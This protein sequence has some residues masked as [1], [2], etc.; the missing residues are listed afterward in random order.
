M[1]VTFVLAAAIILGCLSRG[2]VEATCYSSCR[3]TFC[4]SVYNNAFNIDQPDKSF[5]TAICDASRSTVIGHVDSTGEAYV[6]DHREFVR[7]SEYKPDGLQQSFSPS[8]FKSY[9]IHDYGK[10]LS[11]IGHETPQANQMEF[12]NNLCVLVPLTAYQ[13]LDRPYGNVVENRHPSTPF[14]DCVSFT[15]YV[16]SGHRTQPPP[17]KYPATEK[18]AYDKSYTKPYQATEKR[19]STGKYSTAYPAAGGK[20]TYHEKDAGTPSSSEAYPETSSEGRA[21]TTF[22]HG[23]VEESPEASVD[24]SP[25]GTSDF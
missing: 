22:A 14:V 23:E 13:V 21:P 20:E 2:A 12:L 4:P 18:R 17:T 5:T 16:P 8:F 19:E 9:G 11:G 10:D 7:I 25:E 3:F 24:E 6:Y 1:A 15:T